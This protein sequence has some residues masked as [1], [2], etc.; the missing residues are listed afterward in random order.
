MI[1]NTNY[2]AL[3]SE[4]IDIERAGKIKKYRIREMSKLESQSAFNI[5][6]ANGKRDHDKAKKLDSKLIAIAVKEVLKDGSLRD[7]TFEE[8]ETYALPLSRKLLT[9]VLDINGIGNEDA[10]EKN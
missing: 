3:Q 2:E 6:K 8:A 5:T 1:D 4:D 10:D 9:A 7:I